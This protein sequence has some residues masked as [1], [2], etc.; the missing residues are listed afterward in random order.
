MKK[1]R[2]A[3]YPVKEILKDIQVVKKNKQKIQQA[4][5]KLKEIK[6]L[7]PKSYADIARKYGVTREYICQLA[8]LKNKLKLK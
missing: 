4:K 3:K 8:T 2:K 1:G 5:Q 7:T 6:N